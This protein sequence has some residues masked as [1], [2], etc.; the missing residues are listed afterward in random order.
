MAISAWNW[1]GVVIETTSTA[2]SAISARQSDPERAKPNSCGPLRRQIVG[3]FGQMREA[4][5]RAVAEH[6]VDA[7]PRQ[8]VAFPHVAGPDQTDA[9]P[10]HPARSPKLAFQNPI[11]QNFLSGLTSKGVARPMQAVLD[12]G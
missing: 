6:R 5:R 2:G 3:D 10:V 11:P 7:G 8:R 4:N 12:Q 9:Q 1:L